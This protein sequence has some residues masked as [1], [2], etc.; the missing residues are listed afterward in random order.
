M[1]Q[2][3]IPGF[4]DSP[5]E[6]LDGGWS[7]RGEMGDGRMGEGWEGQLWLIFKMNNFFK[8]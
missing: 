7:G 1:S 2:L 6:R 5:F 3:N 8:N 4:V